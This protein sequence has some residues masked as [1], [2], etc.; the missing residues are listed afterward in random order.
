MAEGLNAAAVPSQPPSQPYSTATKAHTTPQTAAPPQTSETAWQ[1]LALWTPVAA[2]APRQ[3]GGGCMVLAGS[4]A[5]SLPAPSRY[6]PVAL[7]A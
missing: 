3:V 6:D 7:K 2:G 5:F 4:S 1:R